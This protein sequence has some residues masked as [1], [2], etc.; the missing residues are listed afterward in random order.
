MVTL[1]W[2]IINDY[3]SH[4]HI[5]FTGEDNLD[6]HIANQANASGK[7]VT[8][9]DDE[10]RVMS[11]LGKQ[12]S[13]EWASEIEELALSLEKPGSKIPHEFSDIPDYKNCQY[14]YHLMQMRRK[15]RKRRFGHYPA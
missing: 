6:S 1:D 2:Q 3:A 14:H 8:V 7:T 11:N 15:Q 5:K 4:F 9:L 10:V 12:N 13:P